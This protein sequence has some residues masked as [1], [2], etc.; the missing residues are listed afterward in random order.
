MKIGKIWQMASEQIQ[1]LEQYLKKKFFDKKSLSITRLEKLRDGWE[2]DNYVLTVEYD[3]PRT[4]ADWVWRIYSGAGSQAKA[5]R[6]FNGMR[7]LSTADYPVPQVLL[8]ETEYSSVNRPFIIMEYIRGDVMWDLLGN[9]SVERQAQLID[10][11]CRLFVQLH[12][13]D[14]KHF[15]DSLPRDDPFFFID[16]WLDDARSTLKNFPDID[17]MQFLEWVIAQHASFA[18]ARPSPVHQ[19]FH[20]GNILVGADDR[21]LVIDWTSFD[22]TDPRFDLAWTLVLAHAH[23]WAGMR[24]QILQGYERHLGKSVEQIEAFEAIACMRR[25]FDLAVSLKHGSQRMGMN[26]QAVESM[27]ANMEAHRRVYQLFVERTSLQIEAFK[28]LFGK[29]A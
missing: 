10:R 28:N 2:S 1:I 23:G 9:S 16:H 19:D 7:K 14:S 18:C 27:R 3:A 21:A 5:E 13:L 22:I 25:L 8:L 29:S 15:D 4:R 12:D 20:P 24:D 6:E 26:A 11:F 17:A